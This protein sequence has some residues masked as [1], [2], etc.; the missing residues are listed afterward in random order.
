MKSAKPSEWEIEVLPSKR[1][2][3][4]LNLAF[5]EKEMQRIRKAGKR[6]QIYL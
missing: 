2:K 6:G 3:I 1:T 5:S 4:S